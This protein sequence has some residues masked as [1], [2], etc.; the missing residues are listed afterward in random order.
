[1][2][3]A[4]PCWETAMEGGCCATREE[5]DTLLH[6]LCMARMG[7]GLRVYHQSGEARLIRMVLMMRESDLMISRVTEQI[8]SWSGMMT[9]ADGDA[10]EGGRPGDPVRI[11]A[12]AHGDGIASLC[13]SLLAMRAS[14]H[15]L[16]RDIASLAGEILPN[17]SALVGPLV[18]ARLLAAAGSLSRLSRMPGSAIQVI[19]ARNA[20]F[21]HRFSGTPPPKHGLIFEHKRVHAAPRKLRGRVARTLAAGLAGAARIDY[22]RGSADPCYTGRASLR[23]DRAGRR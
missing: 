11:L 3:E 19:G 10:G 16:S 1:M 7:A 12:D 2:M 23:V 17:C 15:L 18:A 8:E 5:Y 13:H 20:F 6:D 22:F 4:Y 14:R 21:S 9:P